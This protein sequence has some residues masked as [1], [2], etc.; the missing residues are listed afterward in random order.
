MRGVVG[1]G[2]GLSE[3]KELACLTG[4]EVERPQGTR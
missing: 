3:A 2:S 1:A 4:V